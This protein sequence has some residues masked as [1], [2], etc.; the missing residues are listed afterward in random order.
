M[1][2]IFISQP[3][4]GMTDEE[5]VAERNRIVDKFIQGMRNQYPYIDGTVEVV[6]DITVDYAPKNAS[7]LWYLTEA[8]RHLEEADVI[9]FGKGW[10]Q[11]SGCVVERAVVEN[12]QSMFADRLILAEGGTGWYFIGHEACVRLGIDE[13]TASFAWS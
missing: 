5:I 12:Y 6:N 11:A 9:I 4:H 8:I 7:R 1:I 10:K 3:M 2:K 13:V